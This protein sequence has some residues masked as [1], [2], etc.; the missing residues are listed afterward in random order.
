VKFALWY[1]QKQG[2]DKDPEYQKQLAEKK[3]EIEQAAEKYKKTPP[4]YRTVEEKLYKFLGEQWA[5][6]IFLLS[7]SQLADRF[8]DKK[9]NEEQLRKHPEG[10][11]SA[12]ASWELYQQGQEQY[13][14]LKKQFLKIADEKEIGAWLE[15]LYKDHQLKGVEL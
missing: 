3:K 14:T 9:L 1:L 6:Y 4:D 13:K 5:D 8:I 2:W 11:K 15:K 12:D 7:S 10:S